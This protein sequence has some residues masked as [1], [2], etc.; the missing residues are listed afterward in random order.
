MIVFLTWYLISASDHHLTGSVSPAPA[1]G[2]T[3]NPGDTISP[4]FLALRGESACRSPV[5]SR[6][7]DLRI[8]CGLWPACS[9]VGVGDRVTTEDQIERRI[10]FVHDA[11]HKDHARMRRVQHLL[12]FVGKRF[13]HRPESAVTGPIGQTDEFLRRCLPG[14]SLLEL[15]LDSVSRLPA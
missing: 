3:L 4:H 5:S 15:P 13:P 1:A 2:E 6:Q 8:H 14:N 12:K 7:W 11:L 10:V 9:V